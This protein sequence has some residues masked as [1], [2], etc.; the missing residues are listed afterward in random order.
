MSKVVTSAI[1]D[2]FLKMVL[3]NLFY[4]WVADSKIPYNANASRWKTS[5]VFVD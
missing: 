3:L 5:A 1:A 2:W 4:P